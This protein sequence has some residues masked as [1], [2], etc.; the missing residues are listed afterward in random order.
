M[1]EWMRQRNIFS[2]TR[3]SA[4]FD[5][6]GHICWHIFGDQ[7]GFDDNALKFL[8]SY[9]SDR[10]QC[11]QINWIL[12]ETTLL[13]CGVMKCAG[14]PAILHLLCD[15]TIYNITY[16]HTQLYICFA[17][18]KTSTS[19]SKIKTWCFYVQAC[20]I[21]KKINIDDKKNWIYHVQIFY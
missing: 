5:S 6:I 3:F 16:M 13:I 8:K 4:T 12:S 2:I 19:V 1:L 7:Y 14:T 9:L 17:L 10:T 11:V 21:N 20:L 15:Y 18:K